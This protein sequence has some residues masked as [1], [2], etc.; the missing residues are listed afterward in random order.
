MKN[1]N[2]AFEVFGEVAV[3]DGVDE[4]V[5]DP[6]IVLVTP[7]LVVGETA[8]PFNLKTHDNS[9]TLIP[10]QFRGNYVFLNF[11]STES[12]PSVEFQKEVQAMY[13][14]LKPKHPL[15]LL[16]VNIDS[17]RKVAIEH[18]RKSKLRGRH[19][20]TD[21]WDHRTLEAFGVRAIPSHW[22]IDPEGKIKMTHTDIHR[23]VMAGKSDLATIVSDRIEGKDV[24]T[25]A[26]QPSVQGDTSKGDSTK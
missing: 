14:Q 8:P 22:L 9:A 1:R 21:G 24:P 5:L 12:P 20:F 6:I 4:L 26:N 13:A 11:W 25:P 15:E 17:K 2:F 16:S 7:L 19:G 23:A 10:K 3:L 18:I